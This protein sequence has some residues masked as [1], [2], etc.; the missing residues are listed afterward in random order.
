MTILWFYWALSRIL[1]WI[2]LWIL[3]RLLLYGSLFSVPKETQ[4]GL[5]PQCFIILFSVHC[6]FFSLCF[7]Y[8]LCMFFTSFSFLFFTCLYLSLGCSFCSY[9][10]KA[11][12][13]ASVYEMCYINKIAPV[14]EICCINK[15]ASMY[16]MWSINKLLLWW[17]LICMSSVWIVQVRNIYFWTNTMCE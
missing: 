14:Y 9:L 1:L 13:I 7:F 3:F 8:V 6:T 10:W 15:L 4:S 17:Y 11:H 5:L 2:L 16:E 12:W